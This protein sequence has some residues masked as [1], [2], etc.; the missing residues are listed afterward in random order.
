MPNWLN[1]L[2]INFGQKPIV[3]A[4]VLSNHR[5]MKTQLLLFSLFALASPAQA[6]L[7]ISVASAQGQA[8]EWQVV[9]ENFI[10]HRRADFLRFGT[11]SVIDYAIPLKK[12]SVF[13]RPG[14]FLMFANSTY[15]PHRF[16]VGGYGLQ[17]NIEFAFWG[18]T[19]K[20]GDAVPFRPFL[21]LSPALTVVNMRYD[22]YF[23][24]QLTAFEKQVVKTI[25]PNIGAN[26][27]VEF[28]LS[29]LVTI[30]P[31]VG[32]RFFPNLNW[33]GFTDGVTGGQI[34][35]TYDR[36]N[37]RHYNFGIRIGLSY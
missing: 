10:V 9:T 13:F 36:T 1:F 5:G 22:R 3:S 27:F 7:G 29:Q 11:S 32:I 26:L 28:K 8:I 24:E 37:L 31:M 14:I 15:Y 20:D 19:D 6:Q 18:E 23:S 4:A 30:A 25:S 2:S 12:N 21:Q 16:Q 34:V 35:G 17:G 33:K